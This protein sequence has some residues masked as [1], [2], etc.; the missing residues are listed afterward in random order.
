MDPR[1]MVELVKVMRFACVLLAVV[2][3]LL[4]VV[5]VVLVVVGVVHMVCE[6]ATAMHCIKATA[7]LKVAEVNTW[8]LNVNSALSRTMSRASGG[9][10]IAP[11][12][13]LL[14]ETTWRRC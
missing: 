4:A 7:L 3:V 2:G 8:K 1:D 5:G 11:M 14:T 13:S 12:P 10:R 9:A 6:T